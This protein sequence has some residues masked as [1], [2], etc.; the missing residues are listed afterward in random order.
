MEHDGILHYDILN[1]INLKI[2]IQNN[3][4][5][6]PAHRLFEM[7]ARRNPKRSFLF[8]SK[9]LGKHIPV[10]PQ[11]SLLGGAALGAMYAKEMFKQSTPQIKE[12]AS[13]IK[14]EAFTSEGYDNIVKK[15]LDLAEPTLFIGFAETATA[16]GHSVFNCFKSDGFYIHTTREDI[17]ENKSP[18]TFEEEH[19]H[20]TS[21]RVYP[22]DFQILQSDFPVV[23]VDDEITTGK[24][25]LNIISAIH[26]LFPRKKYAVLSLLDWRTDRDKEEFKK[27][28]RELGIEIRVLSLMSGTID[29][30]GEAITELI[31]DKNEVSMVSDDA[32]I[33]YMQLGSFFNERIDYPSATYLRHTGRF[34]INS[35]EDKVLDDQVRRAGKF[36]KEHRTGDRVLCMGT[37]EFMYIPMKIASYMGNNVLFQSTTRSPIHPSDVSGYGVR[38][39]FAFD[40]P[41]DTT[42]TNYIYNIPYKYYDELYLFFEKEVDKEKMEPIIYILKRLGIENINIV[43]FK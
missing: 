30:N 2:E 1:R 12:I 6:I 37:G 42:I 5:D 18:I 32:K 25:A 39:G 41:E 27:M 16:L 40:N 10:H 13:A 22:L 24:T 11:I 43:T 20:A 29:V 4:Y 35:D 34:G 9:I 31:N 33:N 15:Q 21:H 23:L 7:A 3:P 14:D 38:N 26:K 19:S 17:V 8:V 36:L 28:E